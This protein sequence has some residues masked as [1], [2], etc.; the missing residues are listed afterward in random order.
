MKTRLGALLNAFRDAYGE[1][2]NAYYATWPL[3]VRSRIE[4]TYLR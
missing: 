3:D 2:F 4:A 1:N